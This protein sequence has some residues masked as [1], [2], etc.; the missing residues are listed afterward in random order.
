[1]GTQA[2]EGDEDGIYVEEKKNGMD[3]I[4]IS[5]LV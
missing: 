5:A 1:L 3:V 4:Y 2:G